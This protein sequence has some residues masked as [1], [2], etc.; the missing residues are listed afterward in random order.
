MC[1]LATDCVR[2]R[3]VLGALLCAALARADGPPASSSGS[4]RAIFFVDLAQ[5]PE[6]TTTAGLILDGGL[7]RD[8]T[9]GS[10]ITY[11]DHR[12]RL[13]GALGVS[14]WRR[15]ELGAVLP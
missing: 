4:P 9:P 13:A 12:L 15:L 6:A 7:Q 10:V 5:P 14:L 3:W 8:A 11:Y 1:G 2:H